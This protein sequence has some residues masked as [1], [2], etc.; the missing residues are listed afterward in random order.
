MP[1]FAAIVSG[2]VML[3]LYD[4]YRKL[5]VRF[6]AT[7]LLA[8]ELGKKV[9]WLMNHEHNESPSNPVTDALLQDALKHAAEKEERERGTIGADDA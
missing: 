4:R 5:M 8:N 3:F 1:I 7:E 9:I 2:A 6:D